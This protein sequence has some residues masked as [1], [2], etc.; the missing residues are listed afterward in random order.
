MAYLGL[1]PFKV[2]FLL[3]IF[4]GWGFGFASVIMTSLTLGKAGV[5]AL[6]KRFLIW[7]EG[8]VRK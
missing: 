8:I 2:P 4:L 6:L 5:I 1:L 7:R 3:Y